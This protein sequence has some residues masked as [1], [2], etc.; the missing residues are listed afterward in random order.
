MLWQGL[1]LGEWIVFLARRWRAKHTLKLGML[2]V[3]LMARAGRV[4]GAAC[5]REGSATLGAAFCS[6]T[7]K[8][9]Q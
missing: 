9:P 8:A 1:H 3:G 7:T 2:R 4:A 6:S 5:G